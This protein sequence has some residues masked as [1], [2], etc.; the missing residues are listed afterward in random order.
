MCVA[1][2]DKESTKKE[3]MRSRVSENILVEN[4]DKESLVYSKVCETPRDNRRIRKEDQG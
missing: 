3:E 1:H 4:I 2:P